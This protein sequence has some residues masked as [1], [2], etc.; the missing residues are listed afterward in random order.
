MRVVLPVKDSTRSRYRRPR[1]RRGG[2]CGGKEYERYTHSGG[3]R[4]GGHPRPLEGDPLRGRLRGGCRRQRGAGP[5]LARA[6]ESGSRAARHLDAG[7]RRHQPAARV[8]GRDHRWLSGRHD[9]RSRHGRNRG[10]GDAPG[11]VRFRRK[12]AVAGEAAAHRR[13]RARCGQ[14]PA[15]VGQA[16]RA[17][18]VGA[19][20]QEPDH[21]T[22]ARGAAADR[23]A[24]LVRAAGRRA[25]LRP[26]S[27]RAL[28][29]RA[30]PAGAR[31]VRDAGRQQPAR[32]GC[33]ARLFGREEAGQRARSAGLLE[34][35]ADGTLFIHEIEDLP[36]CVQRLLGRRAR[37]GAL[38]AVGRHASR[39]SFGARV[40][41]SAQPGI[42]NRGGPEGFRRDLLAHLKC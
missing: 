23:G 13:A 27:L 33:A 31:A 32:G 20:R 26:R 2:S 14:A 40:L 36:P 35:A 41:S 10:R 22:A 4:R 1:E 6:S 5:R 8:V 37:V 15:P 42:E 29:P 3:R 11:R 9:V 17:A 12:A 21:A 7:C 16:V 28:S 18:T 39:S 19:G 38:H 24:I 30:Q 34:E 25:G